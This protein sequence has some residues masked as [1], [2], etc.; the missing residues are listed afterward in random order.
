MVVVESLAHGVPVLVRQG[1]GAV[2][3]LGG[4]GAGAALDLDAP[5]V[6]AEAVRT[7]LTDAEVRRRWREAALAARGQLQSWETT[8]QT[9]YK[10][11]EMTVS[12]NPEA[13]DWH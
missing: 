12:A 8:A 13:S 1:T 10:A 11:I 5:G 9:V 7:W 2:E 3:A 4:S 6:L